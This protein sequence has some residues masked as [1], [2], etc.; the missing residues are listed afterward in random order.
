[1]IV[2]ALMSALPVMTSHS[3]HRKQ[4]SIKQTNGKRK[5]GGLV[6]SSIHLPLNSNFTFTPC[7]LQ[8][9]EVKA[10]LGVLCG[11]RDE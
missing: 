4:I 8:L 5:R 6:K 1:M 7:T 11:T 10:W 3:I 2:S 9:C